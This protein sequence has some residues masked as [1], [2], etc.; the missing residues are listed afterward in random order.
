MT[1][2]L[3]GLL[4]ALIGVSVVRAELTQPR[5]S[6]VSYRTSAERPSQ[7]AADAL[8]RVIGEQAQGGDWIVYAGLFGFRNDGGAV[9]EV[10]ELKGVIRLPGV[11]SSITFSH[12]S[13]NWH[14][15]TI[16]VVGL[17]SHDAPEPGTLLLAGLGLLGLGTAL[18]R[19]A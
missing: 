8:R 2:A 9:L 4:A 6:T 14:G 10:F 17:P 3:T 15:L 1:L 7:L 16:G 13:E 12:T 5:E 19:R 11:H 18:R